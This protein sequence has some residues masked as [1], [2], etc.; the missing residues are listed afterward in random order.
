MEINEYIIGCALLGGYAL[1]LLSVGFLGKKGSLAFYVNSRESGVLSVAF[2]IIVSVIGASATLG[3][4]GLSF[5]VGTPGF[6]WLGA[7]AIGLI[8]Q[9]LLVSKK[10]RETGAYTMPGIAKRF[11]GKE[12]R[13]LIAFVIVIAWLSI[14]AAQFTAI[15]RILEPLTGLSSQVCRVIGFF[16]IVMHCLGGQAAIIRADKVQALILI[17]ALVMILGWITYINPEWTSSVT[18]E[19]FN[20][21]FTI[22]NWVYYMIIV[23]A[24]YLIC[25]MI[26]NRILCAQ[27]EEVA[28]KAAFYAALGIAVCA[29]LIVSIGLATRGLIPSDT[30][31][32][33]V[34]I[35]VLSTQF[36][37]WMHLLVSF[38]L[39]SVI[40]SS[41]DTCLIT[42]ANIL[43]YEVLK[44]EDIKV[45]RG[46][47][48]LIG[49]LGIALSLWGKS[50]LSYLLMSYDIFAGGVVV[51]V[52]IGLLLSKTHRV[53]PMYA[54]SAIFFGGFL[55]ILSAVYNNPLY[56]YMGMGMGGIIALIGARKKNKACREFSL[57]ETGTM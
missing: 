54:C 1:F 53:L 3:M 29:V 30:P 18:I 49:S 52:F 19:P 35:T 12:A 41:A 20:Q 36:P 4:V 16:L 39:V 21:N 15:L 22:D 56:C 8:L 2:S 13:T 31:R 47:V 55:G 38:A 6:W 10:V 57:I 48:L 34:L 33:A 37:S 9:A 44:T 17:G 42:V 26:F 51:P 14:L 7:G 40:V 25:P 45:G 27:T 23:G 46:A 11:L 32:D 5:S 28:K 50:I 24:N 43:S